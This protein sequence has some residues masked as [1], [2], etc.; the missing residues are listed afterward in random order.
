MNGQG[1]RTSATLAAIICGV[2]VAASLLLVS[3][4]SGSAQPVPEGVQG[5]PRIV[6]DGIERAGL[7]SPTNLRQRGPNFTANA[8]TR[9]GAPVK[10]VIQGNT[11]AIIGYRVLFQ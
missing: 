1:K 10:I 5:V 4:M 8:L 9:T 11:G 6:L 3:T 2:L 7:H